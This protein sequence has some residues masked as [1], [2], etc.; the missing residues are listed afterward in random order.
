[1]IIVRKLTGTLKLAACLTAVALSANW[2]CAQDR[3]V[4]PGYVPDMNMYWAPSG[5]I[6]EVLRP[7]PAGYTMNENGELVFNT[8]PGFLHVHSRSCGPVSQWLAF[9]CQEKQSFHMYI[10]GYG[11]A[12]HTRPASVAY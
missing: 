11:P 9:R 4:P 8:P 5:R 6:P 1:V 12:I 2:A 3:Y 10:R 7:L